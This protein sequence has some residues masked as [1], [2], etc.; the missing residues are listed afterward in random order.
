MEDFNTTWSNSEFHAY[1]LLHCAHADFIESNDEVDLIKS[2]V[3]ESEY[4]HI[5]KE[6]DN[7]NDYQSIQKIMV[8][9][10]RLNYSGD[11]VEQLFSEM[12]ELETLLLSNLKHDVTFPPEYSKLTNLKFG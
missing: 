2:K 9:A 7:D 3:S 10:K 8:T 12:K 11:Q 1:V 5:H 4:N 6:F